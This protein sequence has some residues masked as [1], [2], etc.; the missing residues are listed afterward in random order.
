MTE[1]QATQRRRTQAQLH[2]PRE[3]PRA[4][5][6]GTD[7]APIFIRRPP[8]PRSLS[9]T[10]AAFDSPF[11]GE[12]VTRSGGGNQNGSLCSA[13]W[14]SGCLVGWR[15]GWRW[16]GFGRAGVSWLCV[17]RTPGEVVT[18][19]FPTGRS[20]NARGVTAQKCVGWLSDAFSGAK[21]R[22]CADGWGA[23]IRTSCRCCGHEKSR[24]VV[25]GFFRGEEDPVPHL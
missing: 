15:G 5:Q 8:Q 10:P 22:G 2:S 14:S 7:S 18:S 17:P 12:G 4:S 16:A 20:K 23:L 1:A 9:M 19:V 24:G 13:M 21:L 11:T 25:P 3:V 6:P